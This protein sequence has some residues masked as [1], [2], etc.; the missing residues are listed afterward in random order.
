MPI[1]RL[2][3]YS[4][5]TLDIE[6]SRR[7]YTDIMG[8]ETGFRPPF[9]FPGLWLYNGAHYPASS[10]VVHVIGIDPNDPQGLKDYL[11]DR[12]IASL[13]GTGTVD[14]MAFTATGLT[15]MRER[16][17]RYSIAFRERTVPSLGLHQVFLEDPSGVTIEL[18]YPATEAAAS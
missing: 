8:F 12:D 15:D 17:T 3:H 14:H 11:G 2:D 9:D 10:G 16:L 18:N 1:G 5:R 4:I 7:F 6:A 13:N